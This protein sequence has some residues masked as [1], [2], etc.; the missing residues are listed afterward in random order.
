MG[1]E[2][3]DLVERAGGVGVV[4]LCVPTV[5]EPDAVWYEYSEHASLI[6][7]LGMLAVA[8]S[9]IVSQTSTVVEGVGEGDADD[10]EGD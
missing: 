5:L 2:Y 8:S 9:A 4:L 7:V 1:E 6:Q 10:D 3:V